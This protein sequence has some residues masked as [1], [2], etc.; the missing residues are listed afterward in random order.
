MPLAA[1]AQPAP[2]SKNLDFTTISKASQGGAP[3]A[4][5]VVTDKTAYA[6]LFGGTAP[7]TPAVDFTKEEVLLVAM[8]QKNTGG[9]AIEIKRVEYMTGGITGGFAFVH[10]VETSPG[11]NDMVTMALTAPRHIVKLNKGPIRYVFVND[12]PATNPSS[13]ALTFN[14]PITGYTMTITVEDNGK[15]RLTQSS[16]TAHYMPLDGQATAA[17]LGNLNTVVKN[18]IAATLPANI[19]DPRVFIVAPDNIAL[20][21]L[22]GTKTYKMTAN[23]NYYDTYEARVKPVVAALEAIA[24]RLKG[25]TP[26]AAPFDKLYHAYIGG[27]VAFQQSMTLSKDGAVTVSRTSMHVGGINKTYTGQATKAELDAVKVAFD[28]AKVKTLP[29]TIDDPVLIMDIPGERLVSTIGGTDYT[30]NV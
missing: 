7:A 5:K 11:P 4:Q 27:F 16:P 26:P 14:Q 23:Y 22:Q 19:P 6:A 1:H 25:V 10:Y 12:T 29:K 30:L 28:A 15:A 20:T 8:G 18:A 24:N 3:A 9:Y 2:I 17:E 21:F 13:T